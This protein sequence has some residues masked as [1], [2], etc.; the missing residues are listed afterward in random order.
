MIAEIAQIAEIAEEEEQPEEE[1]EPEAEEEELDAT[2]RAMWRCAPSPH[3]P[4]EEV[5]AS[6]ALQ[7]WPPCTRNVRCTR[8]AR[9]T[10]RVRPRR[11][12]WRRGSRSQTRRSAQRAS[13]ACSLIH[14]WDQ[15]SSSGSIRRAQV[16]TTLRHETAGHVRSDR[17]LRRRRARGF[18]ARLARSQHAEIADVRCHRLEVAEMCRQIRSSI[19]RPLGISQLLP[20]APRIAKARPDKLREASGSGSQPLM[21]RA[22]AKPQ[23]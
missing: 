21:R 1:E 20:K 3:M 12:R 2:R 14:R 4:A 17:S 16:Q 23:Y 22:L 5:R 18:A 6:I 19:R 10:A 7:G 11:V 13:P 15:S 9:V 8:E